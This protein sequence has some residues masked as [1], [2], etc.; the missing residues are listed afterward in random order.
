LLRKKL[1]RD[2]HLD[3]VSL[4]G[5]HEQRFVLR[6][7]PETSDGPIVGAEVHVSAKVRVR[8]SG[9]TQRRFR[10]R[11]GL[12]VGKDR[13]VGNR[14]NQSRP[15]NR[16]RNSENNVPIPTLASQRIS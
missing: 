16:G 6:L 12:Q 8:V 14:L 3:V 9:N 5:E 1:I 13:R 4:A 11:V 7:P 2:S 15:K 10:G